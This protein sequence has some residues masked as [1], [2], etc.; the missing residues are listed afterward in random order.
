MVGVFQYK[1]FQLPETENLINSSINKE[2]VYIYIF[3]NKNSPERQSTDGIVAKRCPQEHRLLLSF[4]IIII[5]IRLLFLGLHT[6]CSTSRLY[7]CHSPRKEAGGGAE[8]KVCPHVICFYFMAERKKNERFLRHFCSHLI[9][10]NH[11]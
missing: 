6:G 10:E 3:N 9:G 5:R 4:H 7:D 11:V 2:R 1:Y 8:Q